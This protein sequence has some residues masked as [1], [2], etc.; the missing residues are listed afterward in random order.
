VTIAQ[1]QQIFEAFR[2]ASDERWSDPEAMVAL[3]S[4]AGAAAAY[5]SR[6]AM[7]HA[8]TAW[9]IAFPDWRRDFTRVVIG[10]D[11]FAVVSRIRATNTGPFGGR[12]ATNREVDFEGATFFRVSN[13]LIEESVV[14]GQE[15][16]A[17]T[18][19]DQLGLK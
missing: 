9:R 7:R 10:E 17:A 1:T 6:D 16:L 11:S 5:G 19:N 8:E 15:A 14:V 2:I 3:Y 18:L 4:D 12:P 13:G